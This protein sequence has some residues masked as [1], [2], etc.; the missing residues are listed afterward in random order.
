MVPNFCV[1][2]VTLN[3]SHLEILMPIPLFLANS[4]FFSTETNLG[5]L[6]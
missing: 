6:N 1:G 3:L 4:V 5:E 2:G